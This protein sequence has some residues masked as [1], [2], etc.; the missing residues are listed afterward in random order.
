[1]ANESGPEVELYRRVEDIPPRL[2]VNARRFV[3]GV[4]ADHTTAMQ[5][6]E[7]KGV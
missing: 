5:R 2:R 7:R 6:I 4:V 3:E 1:V